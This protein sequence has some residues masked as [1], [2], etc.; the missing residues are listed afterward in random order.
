MIP[1]PL[2]LADVVIIVV[3]YPAFSDVGHGG[4]CS[5][6][7]ARPVQLFSTIFAPG[8]DTKN[9]HFYRNS[10]RVIDLQPKA[11]VWGHL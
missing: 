5:N 7:T 11:S 8:L 2:R 3:R 1:V 10:L 6:K 9:G 4:Y